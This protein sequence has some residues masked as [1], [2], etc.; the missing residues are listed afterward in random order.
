MGRDAGWI[1]LYAGLAGGADAILIP[2]RPFDIDQVCHRLRRRH[3]GGRLF[4]IVVT[5][6]G[7]SPVEG[8]LEI[9]EYPLDRYGWPKFGGISKVVAPE[10]EDRTGYET[11]ITILGHLQRGGT[12][13]AFDRILATR[14]GVAAVDLA[15]A[16]GWGNMVAVQGTEVVGVPLRDAV[17]ERKVVP[18]ELWRIPE[19][20]F[21]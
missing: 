3:V 6:E 11:R 2:E 7:A 10:I 13:T 20:V 1:A 5:A 16:G 19:A 14:L 15:A 18:Q 8:T 17:A 9:P 21:G 4:S 12:P